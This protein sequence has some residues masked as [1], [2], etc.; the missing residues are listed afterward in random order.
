M[1]SIRDVISS[2]NFDIQQLIDEIV[3]E[4]SD[5]IIQLNQIEQLQE[6]IDALDQRIITIRA[7]EQN[8]GNVYSFMAIQERK[9]KGLQTDNV[10]LNFTGT[11]WKTFKLVKVSTGW[12]IQ[13][14]YNVHGEDIR[15]NF[16]VKYDFVG[17][18][19][20][21]TEVLAYDYIFPLLEKKI[22]QKLK[23]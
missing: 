4:L 1:K 23:I 15:D 9:I 13:V 14:N 18:T 22:R 19:E 2:F 17:L 7:K 12:E 3:I 16:D 6:G 8:A 10:N 20:N 11:F 21:N 5:D